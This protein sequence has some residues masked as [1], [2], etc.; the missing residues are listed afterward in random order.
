MLY[1]DSSSGVIGSMDIET[2]A[3]TTLQS[4]LSNPGAL[5]LHIESSSR[6]WRSTFMKLTVL[7][8][9]KN[10][11]SSSSFLLYWLQVSLLD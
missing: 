9:V 2:Q 5:A 6:Y 7:L 11:I 1:S 4:S 3:V 8:H 10:T